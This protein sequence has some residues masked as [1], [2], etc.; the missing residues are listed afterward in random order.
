MQLAAAQNE[1]R[2]NSVP[3]TAFDNSRHF[4]DR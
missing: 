4:V 1:L 3:S 2:F